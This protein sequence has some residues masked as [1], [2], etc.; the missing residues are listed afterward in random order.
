M[1][2]AAAAEAARHL[3]TAGHRPTL[4]VGDG[5]AGHPDRAPY[6]RIIATCAV[7]HIL[8]AWIDQLAADGVIVAPL[9][10]QGGLAVLRKIGPGQ[11]SGRL[12]GQQAYFMTM[13]PAD[14]T[15]GK[16]MTTVPRSTGQCG[17]PP[18]VRRPTSGRT[19]TSG[20]GWTCTARTYTSLSGSTIKAARLA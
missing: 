17:T 7:T 18:P 9:T 1:D 3:A 16:P 4:V 19:P 2:E 10:V 13:R 15:S 14:P 8:T 5:A 12:D 20:Y 6:D 11:V